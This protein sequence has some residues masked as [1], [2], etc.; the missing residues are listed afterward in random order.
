MMSVPA[1]F[2]QVEGRAPGERFAEG[3]LDFGRLVEALVFYDR[4][5]LAA[6]RADVFVALC[7]RLLADGDFAE[8]IALLQRNEI[9]IVDYDFFS[10]IQVTG[11][12]STAGKA[13]HLRDPITIAG[14]V[15]E[16]PRLRVAR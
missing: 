4:V 12:E 1:A 8:F 7:R 9:I 10:L 6:P 15:F 5:Y 2:V 13:M 11:P 3:V 14:K 16:H